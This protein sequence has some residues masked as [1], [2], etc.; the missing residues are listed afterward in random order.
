MNVTNRGRTARFLLI[1][2]MAGFL[3]S[4]CTGLIGYGVLNWSVP[5]YN[6]SAGD[7]VPV[8][9]Q[10]N[11]GKVYVVGVG[12]G[13]RKRI[14]LPLWQLTLHRSK[15]AAKKAA[16]SL[17]EYRHSY[18]T[19]KLDGLPIRA[20]PE[21]TARQVYR[22]REAQKVKILKKGEGSPVLAG[23]SPLEG[24]WLEVMTDDGAIGW[25]FSYNLTLFDEREGGAGMTVATDSGPDES[26]EIL[27]SRGWYPEEYRTMI[28]TDKID[29]DRMDPQWGFFVGKDTGI[30]RIV[31]AEGLQSFPYTSIVKNADG[32]YRFEGSSLVAQVRRADSILVQYTDAN[33]MPHAEYYANLAAPDSVIAAE[34]E[35]RAEILAKIRGSGPR[36]ASGNY[37]VLQLLPNGKF[38]WSG[39][40]LLS[41]SIIPSGAGA[42]GE[43]AIRRFL[44][45]SLSGEYDGAISFRF[46]STSAWITFLYDVSK[47][48]LKLEF[49]SDSN[50]DD[51][52]VKA[53]NLSPTVM[54]FKPEKAQGDGQ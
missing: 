2:A 11:I 37:G 7:I 43:V 39:Y 32:T 26:L 53:R 49:V 28:E 27:L 38:L 33:G 10:S 3:F 17:A 40:Q 14:E 23:N 35:R 51:S 6:L 16:A 44:D 9:I 12:N 8:F 13:S 20:E 29:L 52:I 15:S 24:D 19:V 48:G 5:E 25:C 45:D 42:G 30:A 47:D 54:F 36:F 21:N 46:E 34:K 41:P 18:A 50:I 31:S 4:S 1:M 22:L